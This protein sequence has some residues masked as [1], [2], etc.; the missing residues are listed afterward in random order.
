MELLCTMYPVET[1]LETTARFYLDLGFRDIARP[2][3]DTVLLAGNDSPYVEIMLERHPIEAEAGSGPVFRI[4]DVVAFHAANPELDWRF[5]PVDLPTG[6]YALFCDAEG[7]P[8]RIADFSADSGR[9]A[10][11]FR[12]QS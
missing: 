11:L 6:K 12:L 5:P 1:D 8:V 3:K 7:N 2:D 4:D 10:K 9:Y